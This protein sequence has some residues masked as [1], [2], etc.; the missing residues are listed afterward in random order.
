MKQRRIMTRN[1]LLLNKSSECVLTVYKSKP[2]KKVL[3]SK[4]KSVRIDES[5]NRLSERTEFYNNTS[6]DFAGELQR[7]LVSNQD[8]ENSHFKY[9]RNTSH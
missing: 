7:N 9:F 5:N 4:H 2:I 8:Q 3:S 1:S 6:V